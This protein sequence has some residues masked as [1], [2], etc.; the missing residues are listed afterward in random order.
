MLM[1]VVHMPSNMFSTTGT[2]VSVIFLDK[3]KVKEPMFIDASKIG[4][5]VKIDGERCTVLS[6]ADVKKIVTAFI[7]RETI[8]SFSSPVS[9]KKIRE[10]GFSF[11]AG[12]YLPDPQIVKDYDVGENL[13]NLAFEKISEF[14]QGSLSS[15]QSR[16]NLIDFL[17]VSKEEVVKIV[18][19]LRSERA[20][21]EELLDKYYANF[22]EYVDRADD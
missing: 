1:G 17:D 13:A 12:G 14:H 8:E 3:N 11:Q 19:G 7:D 16:K 21:L 2:S 9:L 20:G 10:N 18:E 5:Q 15:I 6:D 22:P 4:Q